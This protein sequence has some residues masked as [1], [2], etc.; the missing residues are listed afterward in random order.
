MK[1]KI[2]FIITGLFMIGMMSGCSDSKQQESVSKDE[3]KPIEEEIE[4]TEDV[5]NAENPEKEAESTEEQKTNPL[6]ELLQDPYGNYQSE[7]GEIA[8]VV[9]G[10]VMDG[11]FNGAIYDGVRIY[12][13]SAGISFS[14]YLAEEDSP[15]AYRESIE[16]AIE[17][18]AKIIVGAG[19]SMEKAVGEL[20]NNY[21]DIAFLLVD[22]VPIDE[23]GN[24]VEIA[25]NVH[26]VSFREEES[27][28]LAGYMTVLEGYHKLGFIGGKETPPVMRY[29]YG[30]LQGIDDA[31][32]DTGAEDVTVEYWYSNSY[33]PDDAITEIAMGW[34]AEG[35]EVIFAC[36]G[37]LYE[38]VCMAAEQKEGWMI[39]VDVDQSRLSDRFLT[40][41]IKNTSNAVII[42][43]D[44][45][46]AA[47]MHWPKDMAGQESIYGIEDN[48][49]GIPLYNTEWR[50]QNVTMDDLYKVYKR[51]KAGEI[52]I[53]DDIS[54]LPQVSY[55][56]NVYESG[57]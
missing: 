34:Y 44:D 2:L 41:A 17:S 6:V 40:S 9:G 16:N 7:G 5:E 18:Q 46:Y 42:S 48:C 27:G 28:Y 54:K 20:Q 10:T 11:S 25:D 33:E 23:E 47:G 30:Y 45:F 13:S 36:G 43:L 12:A 55:T 26:C 52:E 3:Q 51:I 21:P 35:T 38:S 29:G 1:K 49:T 57:E 8:F 32:Q 37:H 19:M 31:V 24:D 50:F 39:G 53:S 14:Y 56:V 22:G 4:V 15:A